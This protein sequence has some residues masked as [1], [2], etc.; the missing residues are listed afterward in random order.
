MQCRELRSHGAGVERW[1]KKHTRSSPCTPYMVVNNG[2]RG[3]GS[4]GRR[5]ETAFARGRAGDGHEA[6]L[7]GGG[8]R[9][10]RLAAAKRG[11][12]GDGASA[13]RARHRHGGAPD[14]VG[15]AMKISAVGGWICPELGRINR[16]PYK[17][18]EIGI[19]LDGLVSRTVWE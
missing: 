16:G 4:G 10:G 3:P 2:G 18:V 1:L 19:P 17:S 13:D 6:A 9:R 14:R 11:H 5:Q 12:R 8:Q 7:V 15:M